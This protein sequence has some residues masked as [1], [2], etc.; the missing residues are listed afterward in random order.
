MSGDNP[1]VDDRDVTFLLHEVHDA[2]GLTALASTG[3]TLLSSGT[4]YAAAA[5]GWPVFFA[6]TALAGMPALLLMLWLVAG[7]HFAGLNFSRPAPGA[8]AD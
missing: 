2:T 6:G 3:R 4:G 1:L 8:E 7:G 5:L